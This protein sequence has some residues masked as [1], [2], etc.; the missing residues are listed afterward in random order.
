[1]EMP[2]YGQPV[3]NLKNRISH[4]LPTVL[5]KLGK[6]PPTFPQFHSRYDG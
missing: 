3:E 5:G 1:M 2:P 4:R 6:K